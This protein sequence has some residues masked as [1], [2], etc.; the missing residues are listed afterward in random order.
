V[1][2]LAGQRDPVGGVDAGQVTALAD[3]LRDRGLPVE[4]RVY[5]DARHE[6]FNETN[7]DEVT[8]DLLA[9]TEARLG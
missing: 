4:L 6:V 5:P 7:R 9:W 2:L 8:G 3:L 1:L